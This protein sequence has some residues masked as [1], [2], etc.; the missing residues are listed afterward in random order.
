[1]AKAALT[2]GALD[3]KTKELIALAIGTAKQCSYNFV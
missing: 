2:D 1:M 3:M